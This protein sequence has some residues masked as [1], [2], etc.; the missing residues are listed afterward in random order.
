MQTLKILLV[1]LSLTLTSCFEDVLN[2]DGSLD[3]VDISQVLN[4]Q[5]Y[6]VN[7]IHWP[8]TNIIDHNGITYFLGGEFRSGIVPPGGYYD[9]FTSIRWDDYIIV[10][11]KYKATQWERDNWNS[12]SDHY[13]Y[14]GWISHYQRH[15]MAL[16]GR[17]GTI[18]FNG[19]IFIIGGTPNGGGLVTNRIQY[20]NDPKYNVNGWQEFTPSNSDWK[21]RSSFGIAEHNGYIYISGGRTE[22]SSNSKVPFLND[23]WRSADGFTWER[24]HNAG[25]P[26]RFIPEYVNGT[27]VIDYNTTTPAN[28]YG[29]KMVSHN[30][31]LW[32]IGGE[33]QIF[34]NGQAVGWARNP[35]IW[36]STDG[37]IWEE[38]LIDEYNLIRAYPT[39]EIWDNKIWISGGVDKILNVV[40]TRT[41]E[42]IAG[43]G[44]IRVYRD[45]LYID[46]V[47]KSVVTLAGPDTMSKHFMGSMYI[48]KDRLMIYPGYFRHW[49]DAEFYRSSSIW[50]VSKDITGYKIQQASYKF[51]SVYE[52]SLSKSSINRSEYD[53]RI[54][55]NAGVPEGTGTVNIYGDSGR[56]GS[57]IR[58]LPRSAYNVSSN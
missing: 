52:P 38:Y 2:D 37:T 47:T 9:I 3:I 35:V 53:G 1:V 7:S 8:D 6:Y 51:D 42:Y 4:Q 50:R 45:I 16:R 23:V 58:D 56:D 43:Y 18:S 15:N 27:Y 12:N 13:T 48:H 44:A 34:H 40:D 28:L 33:S 57:S 11:E 5:G 19:N 32:I 21:P 55:R 17:T 46:E 41:D 14:T 10:P 36:R 29:H 30:G 26:S 25:F 39:V 31:Y 24:I 20:N 54:I 22:W 49:R